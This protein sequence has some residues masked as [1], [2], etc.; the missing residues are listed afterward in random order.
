MF[1]A[2]PL[3]CRQ[4]LTEQIHVL[5]SAGQ[6]L[7]C[8]YI[9]LYFGNVQPTPMFRSVMDFRLF[10]NPAGFRGR[11]CPVQGGKGMS[12][13]V[14][15]IFRIDIPGVPW[16]HGQWFPGLPEQ[17]AEI[18]IHAY[19]GNCWIIGHLINVRDILHAG[20]EFCVFFGRD[21]PAGIFVRSKFIFLAHGVWHPFRPGHP[22]QHGLFLLIAGESNG[23]ALSAQAH[24]PSE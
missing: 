13:A 2:L 15:D 18:F 11:K 1:I 21:A 5:N 22:V 20:Y 3:P 14:P 19:H 9:S 7:S 4:F 12:G 24:R 10:G 16:P 17:L 6:T 23:N 8:H